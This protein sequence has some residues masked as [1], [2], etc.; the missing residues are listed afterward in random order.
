MKKFM[1]LIVLVLIGLLMISCTKKITQTKNNAPE[2]PSN[3]SPANNADS[4]SINTTL[5]WSCSDTENDSLTYDVYF[6]TNS[7]LGEN[8]IVSTN[9]SAT[10]YSLDI[11]DYET[12]YYWK[13]VAKDNYANTTTGDVWNFTT[14]ENGDINPGDYSYLMYVI[15][16]PEWK[17]DNYSIMFDSENDSITSVE[18]KINNE[19]IEV[20]HETYGDYYDSWYASGLTFNENESYTFEV[21]INESKSVSNFSLKIPDL[22]TANWSDTLDLTQPIN[23]TWTQTHST[24][25]QE[26]AADAYNWE[27][28]DK[29]YKYEVL[30]PSDRSYIMPANWLPTDYPEYSFS[31]MSGNY[32]T[33]THLFAIAIASDY[34]DYGYSK[35]SENSIVKIKNILRNFAKSIK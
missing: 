27:T 28:D 8:D 3:P 14:I 6:G 32:H 20:T 12:T 31:I 23:F 17:S 35:N 13:I 34:K 22:V 24:M 11:L 10:S 21:K 5:S 7:T 9:L 30:Q 15:K 1:V 16:I 2:L 25:H 19:S 4:V 18:L 33:D 29:V 26:F